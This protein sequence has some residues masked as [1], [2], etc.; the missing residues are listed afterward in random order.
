MFSDVLGYIKQYGMH[1]ARRTI[2]LVF[3]GGSRGEGGYA[4]LPVARN[5]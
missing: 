5:T 4:P 1:G 2:Y 3:M